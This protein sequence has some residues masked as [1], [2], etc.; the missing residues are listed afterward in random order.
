MYESPRVRV[1]LYWTFVL[2]G[3]G[4]G[5]YGATTRTEPMNK[6]HRSKIVKKRCYGKKRKD[7]GRLE[8]TF[9][10]DME[11]IEKVKTMTHG[12]SLT[13]TQIFSTI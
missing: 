11:L 10:N 13:G 3:R 8:N 7:K 4:G 12:F 1:L 5:V 6:E 9:V 2:F